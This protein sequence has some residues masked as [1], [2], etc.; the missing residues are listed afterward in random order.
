MSQRL[1]KNRASARYTRLSTSIF[2]R[3]W[4]I[5]QPDK[6]V[7]RHFIWLNYCEPRSMLNDYTFT[8]AGPSSTK[9]K[10]TSTKCRSR[11]PC[12]SAHQGTQ[13]APEVK[14]PPT[15]RW[16]VPSMKSRCWR[17]WLRSQRQILL[18][19]MAAKE[20]WHMIAPDCCQHLR[21]SK[22]HCCQ[23]SS[24]VDFSHSQYKSPLTKWSF[25]QE[26]GRSSRWV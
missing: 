14:L 26:G 11:S 12:S 18:I 3:P 5:E 9:S 23:T 4:L 17:S 22:L 24:E 6:P 21:M 15:K 1:I 8:S 13:V 16:S 20:I 2:S 25:L 7:H 10:S 19:S